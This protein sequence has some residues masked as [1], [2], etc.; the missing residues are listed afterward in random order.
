ME[1]G[2]IPADADNWPTPLGLYGQKA[3]FLAAAVVRLAADDVCRLGECAVV[4][5]GLADAY[6]SLWAY[7]LIAKLQVSSEASQLYI[8]ST[9]SLRCGICAFW[10]SLYIGIN[11]F[12]DTTRARL[13]FAQMEIE[14]RESE[15]R[16]LRA[17][18]NPRYKVAR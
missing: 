2:T 3:P 1:A 13:R 8:D 11:H 6:G 9:M 14:T 18:V 12:I 15:L 10:V 4:L 16:L 7:R 5:F 17:Q